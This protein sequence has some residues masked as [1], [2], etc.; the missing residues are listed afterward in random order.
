M[1]ITCADHLVTKLWARH[2]QACYSFTMRIPHLVSCLLLPPAALVAAAVFPTPS[3]AQTQTFALDSLQGLKLVNVKAEAVTYKGRKAIRIVGT[4]TRAQGAR[5]TGAGRPP[6]GAR[7]PGGGPALAVVE[8]AD[9]QDGV[10][11]ID[12]AGKPA[13]GAPEAA[14]GFIGVAF[15]VAPDISKYECFYLRPTNARADDQLR[16]NHSVQYISFPGWEWFRLRKETP[17]KYESYVDLV[18]GE[19]TKVKIEVR[20]D[21]ARLYVHDAPQPCL[22]VND[23]KQGVTRGAVAL[24][25]GVG[26]EGYF[27][28]LRISK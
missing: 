2:R 17:G 28:N 5:P 19:W 8:G 20:G 3:A 24:W 16:R 25:N 11:Q 7:R 27:S 1:L 14:R 23:L 21:K 22:I 12:L 15:R 4:Q 6:A 26:T 13:A 9:F 18:P 10:I